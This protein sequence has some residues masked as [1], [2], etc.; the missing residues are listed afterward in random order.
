LLFFFRLLLSDFLLPQT[1]QPLAPSA[2]LAM[3]D[4]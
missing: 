2:T 3:R 4:M 1:Y